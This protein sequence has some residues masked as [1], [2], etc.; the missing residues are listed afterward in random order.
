MTQDPH[1]VPLDHTDVHGPWA[2]DL[3]DIYQDATG[4]SQTVAIPWNPTKHIVSIS[5]FLLDSHIH[6]VTYI[7]L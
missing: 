1:W 5:L 7:D 4:I 6:L 3:R 2:L